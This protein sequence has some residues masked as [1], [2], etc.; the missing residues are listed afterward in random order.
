MSYQ[1]LPPPPS[2]RHRQ[3]DV[4]PELRK[5]L[6]FVIEE[7]R[8]NQREFERRSLQMMRSWVER[9][10][11]RQASQ[12]ADSNVIS[13]LFTLGMFVQVAIVIYVAFDNS[14]VVGSVTSWLPH[15]LDTTTI[16]WQIPVAI[17][18]AAGL[19]IAMALGLV[20]FEP[21]E[22]MDPALR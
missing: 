14:K 4:D 18:G 7:T 13:R 3:A 2:P 19:A 22:R 15:L 11:H 21:L 9:D 16:G 17:V 12:I 8:E 1:S 6:E 5:V 20:E 10:L